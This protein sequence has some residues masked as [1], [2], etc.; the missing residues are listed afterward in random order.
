MESIDT[1]FVKNNLIVFQ[2][3][4]DSETFTNIHIDLYYYNYMP[5]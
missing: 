1:T 2:N 3:K 5:T 4:Y